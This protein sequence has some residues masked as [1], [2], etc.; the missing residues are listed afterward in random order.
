MLE[1]LASSIFYKLERNLKRE[2]ASKR[3]HW[4]AQINFNY[5]EEKQSKKKRKKSYEITYYT[6][7]TRGAVTSDKTN[8]I[9]QR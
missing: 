8:L 2:K 7:Q 6:S 1:A 3:R 5:L 4:Y 9:L